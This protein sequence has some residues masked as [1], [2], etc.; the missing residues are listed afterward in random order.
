MSPRDSILKMPALTLLLLE[1]IYEIMEGLMYIR[2][3][4]CTDFLSELGCIIKFLCTVQSFIFSCLLHQSTF[5]I[6]IVLFTHVEHY[7]FF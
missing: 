1:S 4:T 2:H 5:S 7:F 6:F 3:I